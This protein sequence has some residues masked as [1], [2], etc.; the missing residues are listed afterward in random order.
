M[1]PKTAVM[2]RVDREVA[3]MIENCMKITKWAIS[4]TLK[5]P[6]MFLNLIFLHRSI[7]KTFEMKVFHFFVFS[8]L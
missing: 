7:A 2:G 1:F 6:L 5:V 3:I 4:K 8:I